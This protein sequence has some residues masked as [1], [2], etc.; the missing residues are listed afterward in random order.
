MP[1]E[2]LTQ[3]APEQSVFEEQVVAHA[4]PPAAH[5]KG[6]HDTEGPGAHIPLPSQDEPV[7]TAFVVLLHEPPP[8]AVPFDQSSQAPL[9]SQ[10]PSCPGLPSTSTRQGGRR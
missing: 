2:L 10:L 1:H 9:P 4:V 7:T 3:G 6:A 5:M 8:Q